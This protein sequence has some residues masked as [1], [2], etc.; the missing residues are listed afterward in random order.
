MKA[1]VNGK[2]IEFTEDEEKEYWEK[3][4]V[5]ELPTDEMSLDAIGSAIE[6][7]L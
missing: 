2:T 4:E 7:I 1:I 6:G 5:K 3:N